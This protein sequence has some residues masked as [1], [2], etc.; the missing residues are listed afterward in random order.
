[1]DVCRIPVYANILLWI[2][3]LAVAAVL[4]PTNVTFVCHNMRNMLSWGYTEPVDGVTFK[5]VVMSTEGEEVILE[6]EPPNMSKDLSEFSDPD[7]DRVVFV[8][9]VKDN[10]E[11]AEVPE[12]GIEYSYFKGSIVKIKCDLDLPLVNVTTTDENHLHYSFTHP[13]VLYPTS[14]RQRRNKSHESQDS[15]PE[16][17]YDIDILNQES[18]SFKGHCTERVCQGK[19]HVHGSQKSYCLNISGEMRRMSV[20]ATKKYCSEPLEPARTSPLAYIIPIVLV[21]VGGGFLI[22]YM[23]FVKRTRPSTTI[24]SAL[25]ISER[26]RHQQ[27]QAPPVKSDYAFVAVEPS[28]P[29]PLISSDQDTSNNNSEFRD[30]MRF[31]LRVPDNENGIDNENNNEPEQEELAGAQ[32]ASEDGYT[33]GNALEEAEEEEE[34]PHSAYERRDKVVRAKD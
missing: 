24:P 25:S 20:R 31:P 1:M 17:E 16:F 22:G 2:Q 4:P 29:E 23:I 12:E 10:V 7:N 9:A 34:P 26:I 19:L 33:Q 15:L 30:E 14:R 5:V 11:S 8:K 27:S 6:V 21:V 18:H 28:S 32:G 13:G 3:H